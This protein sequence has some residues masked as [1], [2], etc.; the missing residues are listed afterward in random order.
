MRISDVEACTAADLAPFAPVGPGTPI[1]Q[2]PVGQYNYTFGETYIETLNLS[3]NMIMHLQDNNVSAQNYS[4]NLLCLTNANAPIRIFQTGGYLYRFMNITGSQFNF[5]IT[6]NLS[7]V[8]DGTTITNVL[9]SDDQ[10]LSM[11]NAE[12]I[13][14]AA[15]VAAHGD[16]LNVYQMGANTYRAI[17]IR[18]STGQGITSRFYVRADY[19][20]IQ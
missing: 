4:G 17:L 12:A 8:S 2:L 18:V 1:S 7:I 19:T 10:T 20:K 9:S 11:T 5:A 16:S 15:V 3:P 13:A 14:K 6:R